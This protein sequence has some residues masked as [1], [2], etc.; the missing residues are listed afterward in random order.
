MCKNATLNRYT[1]VEKIGCF[2]GAM[3]FQ[4]HGSAARW[5][6]KNTVLRDGVFFNSVISEIGIEVSWQETED[7]RPV[8]RHKDHRMR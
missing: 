6:F 2:C 3:D 7:H 5:I 8:A 4:K 1:C